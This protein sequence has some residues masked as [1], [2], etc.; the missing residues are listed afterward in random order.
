[1]HPPF[2]VIYPILLYCYIFVIINY[3][4]IVSNVKELHN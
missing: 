2:Q 4:L 3:T 1:M